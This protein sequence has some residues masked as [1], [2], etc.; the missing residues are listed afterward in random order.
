TFTGNLRQVIGETLESARIL[1]RT[2]QELGDQA[3]LFSEQSAAQSRQVEQVATAIHEVAYSVQDVAK[4]AEQ[5]AVD[6][7]SAEEG[8][9]VGLQGIDNALGQIAQLSSSIDQAV[10]VIRGLAD[11]SNRIGGVP[12][13]SRAMGEETY[14]LTTNAGNTAARARRQ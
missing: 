6:V 9:G 5:T 14:L 12:E 4:N 13:V 10:E 2:A 11:D 7:R 3:R 1:S 8:A